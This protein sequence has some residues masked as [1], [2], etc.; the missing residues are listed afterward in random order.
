MSRSSS[1]WDW[2]DGEPAAREPLSPTPTPAATPPPPPPPPV[3][4]APP[5]CAVKKK[6]TVVLAAQGRGV[7]VPQ[8]SSSLPRATSRGP[9]ALPTFGL[10]HGVPSRK[11]KLDDLDQRLTACAH[12]SRRLEMPQDIVAML[13]DGRRCSYAHPLL[14]SACDA[15]RDAWNASNDFHAT[16]DAWQAATPVRRFLTPFFPVRGARDACARAGCSALRELITRAFVAHPCWRTRFSHACARAPQA[17]CRDCFKTFVP[18]YAS[19]EYGAFD[20]RDSCCRAHD[21]RRATLQSSTNRVCARVQLCHS[22][23]LSR[24]IVLTRRLDRMCRS[25]LSGRATRGGCTAAT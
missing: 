1:P 19:M 21:F 12:S 18:A 15:F 14:R 9:P 2:G 4:A 25:V 16:L 6:S 22:K 5:A 8:V 24:G 10:H 3:V 13:G 20:E 23:R 11:A 17:S 7:G